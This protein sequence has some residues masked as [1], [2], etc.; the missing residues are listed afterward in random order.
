MSENIK[1][2]IELTESIPCR[3]KTGFHGAGTK[4]QY[5][6]KILVHGRWWAITKWDDEDDPS[7]DKIESVEVCIVTHKWV[8]ADSRWSADRVKENTK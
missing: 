1:C 6:G 8:M 7:L 5:Y 2:S 3:I 4:G